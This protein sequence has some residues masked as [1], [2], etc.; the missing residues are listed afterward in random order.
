MNK[1][2]DYK[3]AKKNAVRGI[4]FSVILLMAGLIGCLTG[5]FFYLD[6][7][8]EAAKAQQR[9]EPFDPW[10]DS[11]KGVQNSW[12][13]WEIMGLTDEFASD[14]KETYHYYF[15]FDPD[16]Y[17]TII[18]MKGSLG[19]EFQPCQDFVYE[20]EAEEP[21][22]VRVRGVAVPIEDDIRE[23]AIECL[24]LLYDDDEFMS[25][26]YFEDYMGVSLLDLSQKPTGRAEFSTAAGFGIFGVIVS[27]L[28][29]I[30]L[31]AN[32]MQRNGVYQTEKKEKENMRRIAAWQSNPGEGSGGYY[33]NGA[34][35]SSGLGQDAGG[36]Q[37]GGWSGSDTSQGGRW[38]GSDA[39][40]GGR[41]GSD[42]SQ[43][44]G[45][46]GS[47]TSQGGGWPGLDTSQSSGGQGTDIS[48]SDAFRSSTS[49]SDISQG[50]V[51]PESDIFWDALSDVTGKDFGAGAG[52]TGS[53]QGA[54]GP[55]GN[56]TYN[57]NGVRL[58]PVK[59]SNV[60]LGII[61]AI[62]GS[63]VGVVLWVGIS[64]IGFI[65]GFAGFVMLKFALKGYEKLSGKLD[66][67][68][69]VIS[70]IIAAFMVLFANV[71]DYVVTLC[72]AFFRWD[73]SLDTVWY[74]ITNFGS[75]MTDA[76][77]WGG[78]ILNLIIGYGLSIWSSCRLIGAI[79]KYKEK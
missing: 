4:V 15:A 49:Q 61:G 42:L 27:V 2:V 67:K 11:S 8:A 10:E 23:F 69:A 66:K 47:N 58:T 30:F 40:Q 52:R 38:P 45:W 73:A 37:G 7:V 60:F 17:L 72:Q 44:G 75:L 14:F 65:A 21:E 51:Q 59:K 25:D 43:S 56:Q 1:I 33:G 32:I 26:E 36:L 39:P 13:T 28:G 5:L 53:W 77:C 76:D 54:A 71:A 46:P 9:E 12:K 64:L 3:R 48:Q 68:G 20:D 24:N 19:E 62:G 34:A 35:L 18:K 55:S 70:L 74:V 41:P 79:L 78:F 22:P 50:G 16:W 57:L 29:G 31:V 6:S 63:L